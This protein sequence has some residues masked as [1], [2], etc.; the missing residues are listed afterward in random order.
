KKNI[1]TEEGRK[2]LEKINSQ[3][4][5]NNKKIKENVDGYTQQKINIGNYREDVK[6]A[7]NDLGGLS[8]ALG[9]S[10]SAM[11]IATNMI[12]GGAQAFQSLTRVSLAFIAS[13][14]GGVLTVLAVAIGS[15]V[16]ALSQSEESINKL[17]N[18]LA[19]LKGLF[20]VITDAVATFGE[21]IINN[22]I[23]VIDEV[24]ASFDKLVSGIQ[25]VLKWLG[26]EEA[27][28]GVSNYRN[29]INEAVED[30]KSTRLNS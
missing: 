22:I 13:P 15:V 8:G 12:R 6:G 17:K 16:T 4:D 23:K 18:A 2:Q 29:R 10:T 19:P 26:L 24:S 30:R 11:G 5:Q 9:N 1:E 28:E 25:K 20:N 21:M 7:I 14:I 3:L 27:S